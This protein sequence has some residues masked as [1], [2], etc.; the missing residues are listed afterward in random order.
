MES[1]EFWCEIKYKLSDWSTDVWKYCFQIWNNVFLTDSWLEVENSN[2]LEIIW[3][4]LQERFIRIFCEVKNIRLNIQAN[5]VIKIISWWGW[6]RYET[7]QIIANIDNTKDFDNQS[8]EVYQKIYDV[9]YNL[10]N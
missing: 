1:L 7:Y 2:I 5:W 3:L 8:E 9:L 6:W 4:P 10:K